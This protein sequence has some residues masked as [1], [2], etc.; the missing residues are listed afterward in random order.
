MIIDNL[1]NASLYYGVSSKL[2]KA[3]EF[4]QK[5]DFETMKPGRYEIDGDNVYAMVQQYETRPLE[6]G[7]WEAHKK[8]IDV[9]YVATGSEIMG[10]RHIE[11]MKV[12]KEY[13]Q[14]VDCLFLEGEGDFFKVEAGFFAVFT[15]KD[16]HMPC[17][18]TTSPAEVK[19]VVVK[20]AV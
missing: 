11:G 13:D 12:T 3:F 4:L 5:T 6:Q 10:Y 8:Y 7:A 20:V 2:K 19:K 14:S 17:I 1:S 16:A 18:A 15:P 9:Q